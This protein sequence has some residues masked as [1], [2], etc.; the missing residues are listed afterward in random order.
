MSDPNV[1]YPCVGVCLADPE[2]GVCIGC[3]RPP[4]PVVQ[5]PRPDAR[6]TSGVREGPV[7]PESQSPQSPQSPIRRGE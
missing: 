3:G 2:T 6:T 1:D 5:N 7:A 4:E